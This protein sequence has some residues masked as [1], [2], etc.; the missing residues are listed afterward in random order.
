MSAQEL[1][2]IVA[3]TTQMGI[4]KAGTLPWAGLLK[5]EMAYFAR[6][7]KRSPSSAIP[8]Q[9]VVIMGRKTWDSIPRQFRPLADRIN[10]V[11]TRSAF[12]DSTMRDDEK[13]R[14][15]QLKRDPIFVNSIESALKTTTMLGSMKIF[16]IGGAQIYETAIRMKEAKRILF[17]RILN[18]FDFDTRFPLNLNQEG[19]RK[20][21]SNGWEK[22]SLKEFNEWTGESTSTE[23]QEENGIQYIFEMWERKDCS[24][25]LSRDYSK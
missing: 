22:K 13:K 12:N 18:D 11:V 16:V 5:K 20:E 1:T 9:N 17:T 2:L 15:N 10:I 19:T 25:N 23:V 24:L 4:G 14:S 8:Q 6:V 3:A 7:T 21:N